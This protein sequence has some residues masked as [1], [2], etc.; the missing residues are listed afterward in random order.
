MTKKHHHFPP[1]HTPTPLGL[2]L[3]VTVYNI[4]ELMCHWSCVDV[5]ENGNQWNLFLF[6]TVHFQNAA[7]FLLILLVNWKTTS[8]QQ[9]PVFNWSYLCV[10][11]INWKAANFFRK[12]FFLLIMSVC[13]GLSLFSVF[14]HIC[15]DCCVWF[16]LHSV[17]LG[18]DI[19]TLKTFVTSCL[20]LLFVCLPV[21]VCYIVTISARVLWVRVIC[22]VAV[23]FKDMYYY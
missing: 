22:V 20:L 3:H 6:W 12:F 13:C 11:L 17:I 8:F 4:A 7:F 10:L 21:I 9:Q 18:T 16:I 14:N 23:S 5:C 1:P 2:S 15:F 19:S